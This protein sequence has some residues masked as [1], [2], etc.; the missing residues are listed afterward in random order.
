MTHRNFKLEGCVVWG[1]VTDRESLSGETIFVSMS[2]EEN[3]RAVCDESPW[4]K[5]AR[6]SMGPVEM[7]EDDPA[8]EAALTEQIERRLG[9]LSPEDRLVIEGAFAGMTLQGK[10]DLVESFFVEEL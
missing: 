7:V 10:H 4:R 3:A 5:L 9:H 1:Y 2:S 6:R 8:K